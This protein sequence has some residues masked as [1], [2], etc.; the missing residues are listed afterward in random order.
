MQLKA[1]LRQIDPD[2]VNLFHGRPLP[3]V[4]RW[5]VRRGVTTDPWLAEMLARKPRMLVS[6]MFAGHMEL[7]LE[8]MSTRMLEHASRRPEEFSDLARDLLGTM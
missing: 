2:H 8:S 4:V 6:C 1:V 5:A 7:I 3:R